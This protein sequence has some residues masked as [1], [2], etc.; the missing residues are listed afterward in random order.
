VDF[1]PSRCQRIARDAALF[2]ASEDFRSGSL[3]TTSTPKGRPKA[4]ESPPTVSGQIMRYLLQRSTPLTGRSKGAY[5]LLMG[6]G[7]IADSVGRASELLSKHLR[8]CAR[9]TRGKR[10]GKIGMTTN[11]RI[12]LVSE[13][14]SA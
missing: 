7:R 4:D 13:G 6:P 2:S 1:I 9:E 10:H 14:R 12:A 11:L 5:V 3:E 8:S